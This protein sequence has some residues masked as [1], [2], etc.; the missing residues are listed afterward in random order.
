[1]N[2][3][4]EAHAVADGERQFVGLADAVGCIQ[5]GRVGSKPARAAQ[6]GTNGGTDL[7]RVGICRRR[8]R[9]RELRV[10]AV[11]LD[12]LA[13]QLGHALH[14]RL[15]PAGDQFGGAVLLLHF[16]R[17]GGFAGAEQAGDFALALG[18]LADRG[19]DLRNGVL[20]KGVAQKIDDG[21]GFDRLALLGIADH[22]DLRAGPLLD[23]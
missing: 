4:E 17:F 1:M 10:G 23:T 18:L 21:S 13:P 7:A 9:Q 8:D 12:P 5:D 6:F 3:I 11:G 15:P 22:D 14:R 20:A 19:Q 16:K 2:A